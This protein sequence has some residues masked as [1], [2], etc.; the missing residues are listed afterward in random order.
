MF[1]SEIEARLTSESNMSF[2]KTMELSTHRKSYTDLK[3]HYKMWEF[4]G[5]L[6]TREKWNTKYQPLSSWVGKWKWFSQAFGLWDT[7]ID[8]RTLHPWVHSLD[9]LGKSGWD[10][11]QTDQQ[12]LECFASLMVQSLQSS[13]P[14]CG[15]SG[16]TAKIPSFL[17]RWIK[18]AGAF[19]LGQKAQF[20]ND[21]FSSL[22][23]I[24]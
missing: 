3:K 7:V 4:R 17:P 10:H 2:P 12:G 6:W 9:C 1:V 15:G 19:P 5:L 14:W 24:I 20:W 11:A 21:E 8:P 18:I 22:D 23:L 13:H 16:Q